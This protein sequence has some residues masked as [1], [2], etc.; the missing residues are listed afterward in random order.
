[1]LEKWG[2]CQGH[3]IYFNSQI[4]RNSSSC[5]SEKCSVN[6]VEWLLEVSVWFLSN[7]DCPGA[8]LQ[9]WAELNLPMVVPWAAAVQDWA[10]GAGVFPAPAPFGALGRQGVKL[11]VLR[12]EFW[13][14]LWSSKEGEKKEVWN[15]GRK[16]GSWNEGCQKKIWERHHN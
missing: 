16:R 12:T 6:L 11:P 14:L 9:L 15:N 8:F 5:S 13:E 7:F 3:A 1:M 2:L 10:L 4:H